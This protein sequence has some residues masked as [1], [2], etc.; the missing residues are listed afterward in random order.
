VSKK[1]TTFDEWYIKSSYQ[2]FVKQEGLP[3]Y[4]GSFLDDLASLPLEDWARRGGK[5]AYT[6]LGD[7]ENYNL[8]IV[9]I[10]P[11]GELKPEHHMYDSV[12]Y[13][14]K[15]R[16]ASTFWQEGELKHTVEWEEGALLAIPLNAWHQEFNSSSS[17][18][19]RIVF[20]TNMAQVINHYHNMEF[21]FSNPFSFKDRFSISM[22]DF[23]AWEGKRWNVALFETNFVPDVRKFSLEAAP[24]RGNRISHMRFSMASSAVGVH[25]QEV[26]EGTYVSA[27]RHLAGAHVITVDGEGYELLF[28]PGEEKKRS[29]YTIKP[30]TVVAP[31]TNEFHQHFNTGT[32]AYRYLAIR[33]QTNPL[34]FGGGGGY[35][36]T[37]SAQNKDP[38]AVVFQI[39]YEFE[40]PSIREEYHKE[41][42]K[43]GITSRLPP[44]SQGKN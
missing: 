12:M 43:K 36:P 44:I 26:A 14:V 30:F 24:E 11:K 8:Q 1:P 38:N 33:G 16:G 17:E 31:R 3:L 18:P 28:M 15:G 42:V 19:C 27:H 4:E 2:A 41:L 7:Q 9:E 32:S 37:W 25:I 22:A 13:V 29:K 35:N 34:R 20:G 39:N 40:D 21:V 10:P 5:A 6:R 23:Y